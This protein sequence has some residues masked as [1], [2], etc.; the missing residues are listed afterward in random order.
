MTPSSSASAPARAS[1][2]RAALLAALLAL[3][4]PTGAA[5]AQDVPD[6]A[7]IVVDME[8]LQRDA[9]AARSI[10]EQS[11]ARRREIQAAMA[12]REAAIRAEETKLAEERENLDPAEFRQRVERFE[13]QVFETRAFAR[14]E[15]ARLQAALTG[16]SQQ[17]RRR[18]LPILADVMRERR[19]QVLLDSGQVVLSIQGIDVT[20]EVIERVD[21]AVPAMTLDLPPAEDVPALAPLLEE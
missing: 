12:E 7:V 19:A 17:L 20:A 5:R 11:D 2:L 13:A 16:A 10:R 4:A 8:R 3:A 9:A 1:S 6:P 21:A 18:M 15:T 14:Q